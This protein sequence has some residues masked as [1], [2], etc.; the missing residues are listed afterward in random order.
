MESFAN[1]GKLAVID[2]GEG[3]SAKQAYW[4]SRIAEA[5]ESEMKRADKM[6]VKLIE[7]YGCKNDQDQWHIPNEDMAALKLFSEAY[8]ELLGESIDLPGDPIRFDTL[9]EKIKLNGVDL[10][11]LRWLITMDEPEAEEKA[12]AA[13]GD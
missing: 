2:I 4:I 1:L 10:L 12:S 8:E 3:V 5:A 6:R 7:K 9:G 11:R 13:S